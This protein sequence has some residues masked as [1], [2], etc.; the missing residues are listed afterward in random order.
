[1]AP[2][3]THAH[4]RRRRREGRRWSGG[5]PMSSMAQYLQIMARQEAKAANDVDALYAKEDAL[6]LPPTAPRRR[7]LIGR[8]GRLRRLVG[9]S[10][11]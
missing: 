2:G 10:P 8:I 11:A 3:A 6:P 5:C 4:P 9:L 1:M 7:R